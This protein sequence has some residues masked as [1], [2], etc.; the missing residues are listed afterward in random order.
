MSASALDDLY[1][2]EARGKRIRFIREHLLSLTREEFCH[3]C[4][5]NAQS[6]KGWELAWGGGLS[7]Q[8]A[9]KIVNRVNGLGIYCTETWLMHG[10]GREATKITKNLELYAGDENHISKELLLFRELHNSVDTIIKDD[11]MLPF[12]TP[13]NYVGGIIVQNVE[14]AI[15]KECII[16]AENDEL[17]VRILSHGQDPNHY[18]LTCLN[19]NPSLAKKEIKNTA[20]K[21]AAPIVWIR[22][23]FRED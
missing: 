10:I 3:N 17:F 4:N 5:I 20:I 13:G 12:L 2:P 18:N 1:S 8:G 21:F 23:I 9:V 7:S 11:A 22:R 6:L 14:Q 16:I 19:K 15:G